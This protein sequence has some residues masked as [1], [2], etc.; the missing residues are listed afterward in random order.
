[1]QGTASK[2]SA[3]L[4]TMM[5][6]LS[7]TTLALPA[8]AASS[9]Y[10]SN[11]EIMA[12]DFK[13]P[14][15][16]SLR[17]APG[18]VCDAQVCESAGMAVAELTLYDH[19]L[20]DPSSEQL[21]EVNKVDTVTMVCEMNRDAYEAALSALR[22]HMG[23]RPGKTQR[24][25]SLATTSSQWTSK[26]GAIEL[27]KTIG[28]NAHG[29]PVENYSV[30]ANKTRLADDPSWQERPEQVWYAVAN[31]EEGCKKASTMRFN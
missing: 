29:E 23:D 2:R 12:I 3:I 8:L 16:A 21:L 7:S 26:L 5:A 18:V 11:I 19:E 20:C 24:Y 31:R 4:A 10:D 14:S 25:F 27:R 1:M 9:L 6:A 30:I 22:E 17:K 15:A 13:P 28:S